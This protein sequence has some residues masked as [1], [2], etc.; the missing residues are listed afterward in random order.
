[1]AAWIN[2]WT[3]RWL[4]SWRP[5]LF[6]TGSLIGLHSKSCLP[7]WLQCE[8]FHVLSA[9]TICFYKAVLPLPPS[10]FP[11]FQPLSPFLSIWSSLLPFISPSYPSLLTVSIYYSA[12]SYLC[13]YSDLLLQCSSIVSRCQTAM[14]PSR[15]LI[16]PHFFFTFL[17]LPFLF[18]STTWSLLLFPL[19][20]SPSIF[21]QCPDS[22]FMIIMMLSFPAV[23]TGTIIQCTHAHTHKHYIGITTTTLR[24]K[25]LGQTD[26][27]P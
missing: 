11:S 20:F 27:T 26:N 14:H 18:L 21:L 9:P 5:V 22:W 16:F 25:R 12:C 23:T 17:F 1:M 19:P 4:P 24:Q 3:V 6:F 2:D 7:L 10:H 15:Q 13:L 8:V